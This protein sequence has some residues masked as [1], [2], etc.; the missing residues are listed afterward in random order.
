MFDIAAAPVSY[1]LLGLN[2]VIS[3]YTMYANPD[4]MNRWAFIPHRIW[5]NHEWH[6]MITSG[7]LHAGLWHL[8]FNMVT[9]FFFG[10][11]LEQVLGSLAFAIVYI[12]S[13]WFAS[14]F[15][16]LKYKNRPGYVS[17]GASGSISGVVFG[18]ALFFPLEKIFIFP[19]PIGI[20]AF[21]VAIGF[22][23]FSVYASNQ[24]T[25][26]GTFSRVAHEAHL[27][28]AIGGALLTLL[29]EPTLLAILYNRITGLF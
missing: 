18:F 24:N 4:L 26:G 27:G 2:I 22:V 15:P 29:I 1:T 7:F 11:V 19:I 14:F 13:G 10:P 16:L 23:A 28:G 5:N 25:A 17:V 21:L 6:R 20:P 9:L 3:L 8:M 12:G